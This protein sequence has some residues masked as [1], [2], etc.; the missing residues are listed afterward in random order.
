MTTST[1]S[2]DD[3]LTF[4]RRLRAVREYTP[5]PI[6]DTV[7]NDILEVARWSGSASNKQPTEIVVVRDHDIK[8][9]LAEGGVRPA[10]ACA[11]AAFLGRIRAG[12]AGAPGLA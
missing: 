12:G 8:Q 5:Q 10:A 11:V 1:P 3:L 2:R 6:P 7:V 9:K 4:M